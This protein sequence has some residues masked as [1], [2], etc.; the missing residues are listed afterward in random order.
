MSITLDR[1]TH[2]SDGPQA[3]PWWKLPTV[4]IHRCTHDLVPLGHADLVQRLDL[5]PM[6]T[7]C[8]NIRERKGIDW[9]GLVA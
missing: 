6:G 7:L 8:I 3:R 4:K 9:F 1:C 2:P 5:Q